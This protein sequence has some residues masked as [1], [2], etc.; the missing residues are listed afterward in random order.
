MLL[1]S[2]SNIKDPQLLILDI[3]KTKTLI[4]TPSMTIWPLCTVIIWVH[5]CMIYIN[6]QA[7][8]NLLNSNLKKMK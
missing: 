7:I 3:I 6:P 5:L 2:K 8:I 1:K 4:I